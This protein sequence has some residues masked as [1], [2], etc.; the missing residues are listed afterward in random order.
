MLELEAEREQRQRDYD[1]KLL[2]AKSKIENVQVRTTKVETGLTFQNLDTE[3]W[4][5]K[6]IQILRIIVIYIALF[7][8]LKALYKEVKKNNNKSKKS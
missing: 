3:T 8:V 2:L 7:L 6:C 1:K 5:K 4:R